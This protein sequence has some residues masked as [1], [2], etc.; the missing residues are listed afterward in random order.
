MRGAHCCLLIGHTYRQWL[1]VPVADLWFSANF[2]MA[3]HV[4]ATYVVKFTNEQVGMAGN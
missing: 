2:S 3:E 1:N 4:H